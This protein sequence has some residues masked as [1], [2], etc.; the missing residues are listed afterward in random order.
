MQEK[1]AF[2]KSISEL[3]QE[4]EK[5]CK[6]VKAPK[7]QYTRAL[8]SGWEVRKTNLGKRY[9]VNHN[10][11]ETTWDDPRVSDVPELKVNV[12]TD[13]SWAARIGNIYLN[14]A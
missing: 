14:K 4:R 8:P 5:K 2:N 1:H 6:S 9:F 11:K 7:L 12:G 13:E 3:L 10:T